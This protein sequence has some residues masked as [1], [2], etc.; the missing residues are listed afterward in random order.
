MQPQNLYHPVTLLNQ[1]NKYAAIVLSKGV[2]SE[3]NLFK[4]KLDFKRGMIG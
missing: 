2:K 4:T 1:F 3:V